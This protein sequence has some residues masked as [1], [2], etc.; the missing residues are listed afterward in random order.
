MN[1]SGPGKSWW[2]ERG[3]AGLAPGAGL[4]FEHGVGGEPPF[5]LPPQLLPGP[6]NR[7]KQPL[8]SGS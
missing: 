8:R 2:R 3:P 6:S 7:W 1:I 4:W 5:A